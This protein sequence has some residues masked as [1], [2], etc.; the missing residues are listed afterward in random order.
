M[1]PFTTVL[2]IAAIFPHIC[3]IGYVVYASVS[4]GYSEP[5]RGCYHQLPTIALSEPLLGY[6]L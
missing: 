4:S 1:E 5:S 3:G 6:E 2:I